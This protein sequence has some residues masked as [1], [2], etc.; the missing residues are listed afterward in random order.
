VVYHEEIPPAMVRRF[1][2]G[3]VPA[4]DLR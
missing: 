4:S 1:M 3:A 2:D